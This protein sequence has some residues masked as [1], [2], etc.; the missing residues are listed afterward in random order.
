LPP[1]EASTCEQRSGR[2]YEIHTAFKRGGAKAAHIADYSAAEVDD[3]RAP[4]G[5]GVEHLLPDAG[6]GINMFERFAGRHGNDR[7]VATR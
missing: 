1:I 7:Q 6:A 4:V 2:L 5:A 3:Q